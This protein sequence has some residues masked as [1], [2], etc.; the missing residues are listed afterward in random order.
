MKIQVF[1]KIS[2]LKSSVENTCVAGPQTCKFIKKS[3]QHK[4]LSVKF[5]RTPFSTEQLRWLLFKISNINKSAQRCF[6]DTSYAQPI[7]NN[8]LLSQWQTYLKMHSLT[9]NLFQYSFSVTDLEQTPFF[10]KSDLNINNFAILLH[11]WKT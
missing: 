7:S 3:L 9:R 8:L 4:C 6:S 10:L 1:L 11:F 2:A 5:L